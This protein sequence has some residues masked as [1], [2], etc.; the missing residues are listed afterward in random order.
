LRIGVNLGD[1]VVDG[2]N[3]LGDGVNVAARLESL[4]RP[5]G[6]CIS[7]AVLEQVQD[8]LGL[9]FEDLG[10]HV[11]KNIARPV[12]VYRVPLVSEFLETSPFRGL[13]VFEYE[14]SDIFHGRT[15]A[16]EVTR[17]R[18]Q[19]QAEAGT[20]FL[21]IYGMSG[22]GKSSLM[23]AGLL[24]A[25]MTSGGVSGVQRYCVFRPSEGANPHSALG[26]AL[27]SETALPEMTR[28]LGGIADVERLFGE[29]SVE[30]IMAAM[31]AAVERASAGNAAGS[32]RIVVAVDQL[33]E[34]FTGEH[35]DE[36]ERNAFIALLAALARSGFA[37]VV[38]TIRTDFLHFCAEVPG[39]SELKDGLGS[40]ELLSPTGPEI[41]QMIRNPARTAGLRF[42]EDPKEGRLDDVLQQA[43]ASD[44]MSLPLLGFIL[45]ALYEAGKERRVLT[46]ASYRALGGLEGAIAGRADEVVDAM[47]TEVQDTLPSILRSLV[48]V[49]LRDEVV[50][51][52]RAARGDVEST[53]VQAEMTSA[54]IRARLLVSDEGAGG[55]AVVRVAHEALLSHWPRAQGIIAADREFLATRS[56]VQADALRWLA[57]DR[58]PDLLL[59]GGKRLAEAED[60][61]LVR[62]GEVDDQIAEYVEAS[63]SAQR[64]RDE[65][66]RAAERQRLELEAAAAREREAAASRLARRTRIAAAITLILALSASVGA[67]VGFWGQQEASR[68][69]R[70]AEQNA[71]QA[72]AAEQEAKNQTQAAVTAR[73]EALR[74]QSV[75]LSDLSRRQVASGN[76]TAGLLLA[77]E[78]LPHDMGDPNRPYVIDAETALYAALSAQREIAVLRGHEDGV[79]HVAFSPNGDQLVSTSSDGTARIWD[80]ETGSE[81]AILR[82]HEGAVRAATYSSDGRHI[83]TASVDKTARLWNAQDGTELAVLEGHGGSVR[84]ALFSPDDRRII[85]ASNDGTVLLWDAAKATRIGALTGHAKGINAITFSTDGKF[86][87]TASDDA[88][89][90][91][92]DASSGREITVMDGHVNSVRDVEFSPD[93]A[94]LVTASYDE[95]ARLWDAKSGREVVVLRG[96]GLGV[97][98]VAFSPDGGRVA[99]ASFDDT[100]RLWDVDSGAIV[101][102]L[103][104]HERSV[105]AVAFSADGARL[106]TASSDG[107]VRVWD[108][109]DGNEITVLR[110]HEQA[111]QHLSLGPTGDRFATASA[112]G[113][114]RVWDT[115]G[116][117]GQRLLLRHKGGSGSNILIS[118]VFSPSGGSLLTT[119]FDSTARVWNAADGAEVAILG[120]H[121]APVISAV[122]SPDER[123]V[124]TV[125]PNG[126]ARLWEIRTA[127][128]IAV[129]HGDDANP[130]VLQDAPVLNVASFS[131]DGSR[132]IVAAGRTAGLWDVPEGELIAELR[133]HEKNINNVAFS[134]D[135][136]HIITASYDRTARIWN[137]E[138]GAERAVLAGHGLALADTG[139]SQDGQMALTVSQDATARV[140][141]VRSGVEIAVLQGHRKH[142]IR[143]AFS[144]DGSRV[145]TA[146]A[147]G[148]ARLWTVDGTPLAVFDGHEGPVF[149]AVFSPDGKRVVTASGDTTARVWEAAT[150]GLVAILDGHDSRINSVAFS[151]DGSRVTT[152]SADGTARVSQVF[153]TT[154]A[155]IDHA[156]SLVPRDLTPCERKRFFLPLEGEVGR[157]PN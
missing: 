2:E 24:P 37:W 43:S 134:P 127:R 12:R 153:S 118:A 20:A 136:Q 119:S 137:A 17:E 53:T 138:T 94:T 105:A 3:L 58:H 60:L 108:A 75:Y 64:Q 15:T 22:S 63:V 70:V 34:I 16:I 151:P 5:G 147:D 112:D 156:R 142:I 91:I 122:F 6:V 44:P 132:V 154:Q 114:V 140:W 11:V 33:E 72:R 35:I 98:A 67:V 57:E 66:D 62:R 125:T 97:N 141:N 8:K 40:Y 29:K 85:T 126:E 149:Q 107:T 145:V 18:L 102:V 55:E 88:T 110:G 77:L 133:G 111:I 54:L 95:T 113:T 59:P 21:L 13:D 109:V 135:G 46:F 103:E 124:V 71:E 83:V 10:E 7:N 87:A 82:G 68:Q 144:P 30:E 23:R 56:R 73:N 129:L 36:T 41:A 81:L 65:A 39:L 84:H 130:V 48:T 99:T 93:G 155:L 92:W 1:V 101:S 49:R 52:R 100:A 74:N 31:A 26:Q 4:A 19:G 51:A 76:A 104:G 96:H 139:F 146:S 38:A 89:A 128:V 69:A 120:G 106:L 14:H 27:L 150:G 148:T 79:L 116:L 45:E 86:V 90:R 117:S 32:I 123:Y 47:P 143:G 9:E 121:R 42:E 28:V 78:A 157:C 25:V 50:T 80:V 61:L 131:P 115:D 152:A